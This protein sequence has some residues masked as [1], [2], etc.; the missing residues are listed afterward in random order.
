MIIGVASRRRPRPRYLACPNASAKRAN[1]NFVAMHTRMCIALYRDETQ[2]GAHCRDPHDPADRAAPHEPR[3]TASPAPASPASFAPGV[4]ALAASIGTLFLLGFALRLW[5]SSAPL[6]SDEIWSL[7]NLLPI[8][9][10]W[11]ILW[12]ISHDNN[13]FL[14]SLWLFFAGPISENPSW[15][16]APSIAAGALAIPAM[17]H[18]GARHGRAAAVAAAALTAGSFFQV[19]YS[20]GARGYATATLTL[21]VAF[22]AL[23]RAI[24]DPR[25]RGRWIMAAAAGLGLFGHLAIAPAIALLGAIGFGENLRRNRGFLAA[26]RTTLRIFWPAGLAM[27]P[28]IAFVAAGYVVQGGFTIGYFRPYAAAHAIGAMANLEMTTFGLD[29]SWRVL[30]AFALLVL[31]ILVLA[32]IAFAALPERRIA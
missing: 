32:A 27:S 16:R 22:A 26:L 23:E 6:W 12:G 7:R 21:I 2:T 19:T 5:C 31:P 11:Q 18:L 25:G 3:P 13:H 15:L 9:H 30:D 1:A 17:A 10:F 24:E 20:V 29:P 28:T 14:N 4:S 8:R